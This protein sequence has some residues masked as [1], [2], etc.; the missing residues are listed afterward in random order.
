MEVRRE[1]IIRALVWIG[2]GIAGAVMLGFVLLF[3]LNLS[4]LFRHPL[5]EALSRTVGRQVIINGEVRLIAWPVPL[6]RLGG[7]FIANIPGG[8]RPDFVL[9]HRV[10]AQLRLRGF[11]NIQLVIGNIDADSV[12]V[13]LEH[14]GAGMSWM[15][16]RREENQGPCAQGSPRTVCRRDRA[17]FAHRH[18]SEFRRADAAAR[19]RRGLSR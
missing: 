18:Q 5:E 9:A 15:L 13:T 16:A 4:F 17:E 19:H 11:P 3:T 1:L 2:A 8:S 7:L 14:A 6:L 12:N 10:D